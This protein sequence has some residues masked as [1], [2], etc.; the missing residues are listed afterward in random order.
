MSFLGSIP[1]ISRIR[2]AL[3]SEELPGSPRET[4]FPRRSR[5]EFMPT[6]PRGHELDVVGGNDPQRPQ[7]NFLLEPFFSHDGVVGGGPQDQGQIRFAGFDQKSVFNGS[8]G[9]FGGDFQVGDVL[10]Q[11]DG[12]PAAHDIIDASGSSRGN[13]KNLGLLR[14]PGS[15]EAYHRGD[16]QDGDERRRDSAE[17]ILGIMFFPP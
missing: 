3:S 14:P 7:G 10:G 5:G 15:R 12:D 16:D 11:Q 4:R 6:P 17:I 1:R 9:G 2:V 8:G 13:G